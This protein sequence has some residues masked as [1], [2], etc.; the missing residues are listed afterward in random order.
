MIGVALN[1]VGSWLRCVYIIIELTVLTTAQVDR[2]C[3]AVVF[4]ATCQVWHRIQR[5]NTRSYRAVIYLSSTA[6]VSE[7]LVPAH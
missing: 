4:L 1:T 5:P 3:T 7:Q 2:L 6:I